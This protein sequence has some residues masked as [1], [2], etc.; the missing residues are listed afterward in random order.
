MLSDDNNC[1]LAFDS[2][3]KL[4]WKVDV[5]NQIAA[6][7]AYAADNREVYAVTKV[8]IFK[9][10]D[11]G[12][13]GTIV[14]KATLDAYPG[15]EEL[16]AL[17]P[18]IVANGIAISITAGVPIPSRGKNTLNFRYAVGLLD[19]E[20]GHLRYVTNQVSPTHTSPTL[21]ANSPHPTCFVAN[22]RPRSQ[23][24]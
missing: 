19:R 23:S 15:F 1:V 10:K 2:N 6:S 8:A 16:N 9:I 20:T 11:Y 3:L 7:I 17:T 21:D 22:P 24:P 18:T 4:L 12:T 14:W 5:G 13:H